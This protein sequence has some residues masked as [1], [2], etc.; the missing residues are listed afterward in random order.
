MISS[1]KDLTGFEGCWKFDER[2][3]LVFG[4]RIVLF[5]RKTK[6]KNELLI[7]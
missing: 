4:V 6:E 5:G 2:L 3:S 7:S 1:R